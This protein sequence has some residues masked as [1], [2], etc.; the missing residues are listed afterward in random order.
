MAITADA[1]GALSGTFTIPANVLAGAKEVAVTGAG[2]S[3]GTA[4]FTGRTNITV[5]DITQVV[6]TH[7]DPVAETFTLTEG[8]HIGAV[9]L[10]FT[11][12]GAT[13]VL[14]MLRD[15]VN[16]YPG[17]T[18][19]GQARLAPTDIKL[20]GVATRVAFDTPVWLEGST[21]YALVVATDDP[22]VALSV[23]ELGKFDSA[24]QQWVTKQPY[25][26]GVMLSSANGST[27]TAHQE[28]DLCFRL[29]ACRFQARTTQVPLGTATV[30]DA[31]DL[32]GLMTAQIPATG[33]AASLTA[34][35][36]AGT[37]YSLA[38]PLSL[39]ERLT[40]ALELTLNLTC[41]QK[42]SPVVFQGVQ[43][44]QGNVL[45]TGTYISRAFACGSNARVSVT[46]EANTP[47]TSTVTVEL[48]NADGSWTTLSLTSGTDAGD[49]WT[50]R[51]FVK[52][53]F[54]AE[55]TRIRL[56][57]AGTPGSRPRLRKLRAVTTD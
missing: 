47:G 3:Y 30:T 17:N 46:F 16:G 38:S 48:Q 7:I 43:V 50:E 42:A 19:L 53:G 20:G 23:A 14:V 8:R 51:N 12:S 6:T 5:Q 41:T 56:T 45:E 21:E 11:V 34:Q 36:T 35:D 40:G 15:T 29:L 24:A 57:L 4:T 32:L 33:T 9:D 37:T 52:T 10:W 1:T 13:D 25:Q 27:W 44:A 49:G 54:S 18:V 28:K 26:V 39:S 2:G 55:T 31:S 22:N